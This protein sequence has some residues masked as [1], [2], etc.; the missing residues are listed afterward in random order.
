MKKQKTRSL[1]R[2]LQVTGDRTQANSEAR[3]LNGN[4]AMNPTY[5]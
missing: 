2:K 5:P 3:T 1:G 4:D